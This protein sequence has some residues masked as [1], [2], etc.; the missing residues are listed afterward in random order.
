MSASRESPTTL[1]VVDRD[2]TERV[3]GCLA[4]FFSFAT[5]MIDAF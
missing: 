5:E 1:V 4:G 3:V 2:G